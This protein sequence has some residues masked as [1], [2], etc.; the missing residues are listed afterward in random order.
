MFSE[1]EKSLVNIAKGA[2]IVFLAQVIGILLGIINQ[3]IL[4]RTLGPSNFGLFNLGL[5]VI[6]IILPFTTFGLYSAIRQFIPH[7]RGINRNDKVK[8][9]IYFLLNFSLITGLSLSVFLFFLSPIIAVNIFHNENLEIVIKLL[10]ISFPFYVLYFVGTNIAQ[11]FKISKYYLYLNTLLLKITCIVI[12]ILFLIFGYK[13]LGAIVAYN[14]GT[15]LV[16][17]A[18]IYI[19]FKKFIPSLHCNKHERHVKKELFSIGWP[20]FFAG[21]FYLFTESTAKILL[22]IYMNTSDV[23]IYSAVFT[24][25]SLALYVMISFDYIFLPTVAEFYGKNDFTGIKKILCSI[26]KWVFLLTLPM[27][28]YISFFSKNTIFLFYGSAYTAGSIALIILLFGIAMNGLTGMTGEVLVGI[29]KT[30]LNLLTEVFGAITNVG[31]NIFLIPKFGILGAAIGTS[32]SIAVRNLAQ[33]G[34]VYKELKIHPYD[35]SFL[36]IIFS[37]IIALIPILFLPGWIISDKYLF[38]ITLPIFGG[39]YLLCLF[40]LKSFNDY[41][42]MIIRVMLTKIGLKKI[43]EINL[44]KKN[45]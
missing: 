40:I 18:Y 43:Y 24:I 35:K 44:F 2:G 14:I 5:T 32:I 17:T 3:V 38:L 42:K 41:D 15:A 33:L 10:C 11:A 8:G 12:F 23:G 31:L 19:I 20:L 29:R 16:A 1:T 25:A 34:F 45:I 27:I 36:K 28:L 22:G 21:F 37:S 7:Y 30:K 13:L 6:G 4:G 26:S 39:I 9:G